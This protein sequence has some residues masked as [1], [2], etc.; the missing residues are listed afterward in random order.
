MH[1]FLPRL[2]LATETLWWM[3]RDAAEAVPLNPSSHS[4]CYRSRTNKDKLE[5]L[6]LSQNG[7]SQNGYGTTFR[8]RTKLKNLRAWHHGKRGWNALYGR[9]SCPSRVVAQSIG[10][11]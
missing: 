3:H 8:L 9:L 7:L 5:H 11:L 1:A 6:A 4:H 10:E 2:L